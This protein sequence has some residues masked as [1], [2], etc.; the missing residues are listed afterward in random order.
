ML[1]QKHLIFIMGRKISNLEEVYFKVELLLKKNLDVSKIA[2]DS[3]VDPR[4]NISY[5]QPNNSLEQVKF[6]KSFN[7]PLYRVLYQ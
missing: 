6:L 1:I 4:L 3:N 7:L 2:V 5:L